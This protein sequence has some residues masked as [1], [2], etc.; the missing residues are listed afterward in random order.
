MEYALWE[1]KAALSTAGVSVL[2]LILME[3]ALWGYVEAR[4]R[5]KAGS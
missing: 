2:I 1:M 4:R 5:E 3:Y